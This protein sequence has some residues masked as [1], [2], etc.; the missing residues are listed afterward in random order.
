[1][2]YINNNPLA[3]VREN[4]LG[5]AQI[6]RLSKLALF[7]FDIKYRMGRSNKALDPFSHCHNDSEEVDSNPESEEYETIL[8]AIKCEELEE[9]TRW[10]EDSLRMSGGQAR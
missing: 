4:K 5:V 9:N 10:G 1:M 3:Y 8:Y 2:V 6:R 7:D